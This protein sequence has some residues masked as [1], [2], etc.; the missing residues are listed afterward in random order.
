M[1]IT[2]ISILDGGSIEAGVYRSFSLYA[3]EAIGTLASDGSS[4]TVSVADGRLQFRAPFTATK[5][6]TTTIVANVQVIKNADST[7]SLAGSEG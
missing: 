3:S 5:G 7:Y 1:L 4:V 6:E 2:P